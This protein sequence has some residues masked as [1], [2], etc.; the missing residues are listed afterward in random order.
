MLG[1]RQDFARL[2]SDFYKN[3]YYKLLRWLTILVVLTYL[4]IFIIIYL[5]VSYPSSY[6]YANTTEG[7]ILPMPFEGQPK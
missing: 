1:N 2:Q 7:R 6:Y 4:L 3:Q 5:V